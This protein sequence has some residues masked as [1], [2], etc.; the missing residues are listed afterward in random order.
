M[1]VDG[2][3]VQR[4]VHRTVLEAEGLVSDIMHAP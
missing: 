2:S 1:R 4:L 3:A